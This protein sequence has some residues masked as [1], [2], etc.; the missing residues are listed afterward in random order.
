MRTTLTLDPDVAAML[1]KATASG[2]LSFK[3]IVNNA[4]RKGLEKAAASDRLRRRWVQ[5]P[6]PNGGGQL[7]S[8]AEIKRVLHAQDLERHK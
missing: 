6:W 8:P 7:P 4:I 3:D 1:K 2:D 5:R